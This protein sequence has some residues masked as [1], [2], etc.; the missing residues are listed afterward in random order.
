MDTGVAGLCAICFITI[1]CSVGRCFVHFNLPMRSYIQ[2][3]GGGRIML[4]QNCVEGEG[5][6]RDKAVTS[7]AS[8]PP[9]PQGWTLRLRD[10]KEAGLG[11]EEGASNSSAAGDN[12]H[13]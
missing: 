6:C 7:P 10:Q 9:F 13:V 8:Q 5:V 11:K 4:G 12:P 1:R 3:A 2:R